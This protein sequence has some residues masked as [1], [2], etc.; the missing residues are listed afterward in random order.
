MKRLVPLLACW[1]LPVALHAQVVLY[2]TNGNGNRSSLYRV[3]PQ[4][5]QAT[6]VGPVL[7]AGSQVSVTALAFH[8]QT[9]VLYGVSGSE[10]SPSRQLFTIDPVT[11]VTTVI[12]TIGTIR[13]E[14]VSDLSFAADGTL[15]GWTTRGGP[16]VTIGPA[17]AARTVVGSALNGTQGNGLAF[18]PDGTL[19]LAGPT[20]GGSLYTVNPAT[21]ALTTVAPL[22][23]LPLN[24]GTAINA[25]ASDPNGVLYATAR[26]S[27]AQLVTIDRQTGLLTSVGVLSFGEAD[28]LAFVPIPEPA[29]WLALL[30]GGALLGLARLASRRPAGRA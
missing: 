8:P 6:L 11:A 10:Y 29:T 4:T 26:G 17:D 21:G 19:Y 9:G 14:N 3:D 24:F 30:L 7:V 1:F 5:A 28:A 12:G 27:G 16:L 18:T 15:Y 22:G 2:A 13:T 23:N 25:M 20:D